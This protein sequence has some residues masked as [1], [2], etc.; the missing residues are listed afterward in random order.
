[1]GVGVGVGVGVA[2]GVPNATPD[3]ATFCGAFVALSLSVR[4]LVSR[5]PRTFFA[6]TGLNVT[7]TSQMPPAASIP[8]QFWLAVYTVPVVEIWLIVIASLV[9]LVRITDSAA[10]VPTWTPPKESECGWNVRGPRA[11]L[12]SGLSEPVSRSDAAAT[13]ATSLPVAVSAGV[14]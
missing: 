5:V 14:A 13:L 10:E 2:V 11:G 7:E 6:L 12:R 3:N 9:L 1:V 4:V 8:R